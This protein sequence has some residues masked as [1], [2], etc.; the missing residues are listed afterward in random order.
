MA[1]VVFKKG[2]LAN[3]PQELA[4]GTLYV[5]TDERA[6][7]LDVNG[8]SRIRIGDFQEV[9]DLAALQEIESPSQTALY[10]VKDI[11]CLAKYDGTQWKQINPDTGATKGA[12]DGTGKDDFGFVYDGE[13]R[14]LTLTVSKKFIDNADLEEKIGDLG[15]DATVVDYITKKISEITGQE[16][17]LGER[18]TKL[19]GTVGDNSKGLVKDV[20]DLKTK[21]GDSS[22]S[23]QISTAVKAAKKELIGEESTEGTE[24]TI[25]AAKKHAE[26][27]DADL[28]AELIGQDGDGSEADTI[29]GA[30]KYADEQ[31]AAKVASTYKAGGSKNFA[32]LSDLLTK[33]NEGVVYNINDE[34]T[35]DDTFVDGGS[36]TY[37]AG[38]N[39][40]CID[41]GDESYKWDVLAGFVDL[42][43]Y[44]KT[45]DVDSKDTALKTELI[46]TGEGVTAT[47][48]KGAVTEA[49]TDAA[50]KDAALK[51]ELIGEGTSGDEDTIKG[52]KKYADEKLAAS[53]AWGEF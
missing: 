9:A 33:E 14:T 39:V 43:A 12:V 46:G 26:L 38:T 22:V 31:I 52:A 15:E 17:S 49:E 32:D 27:K 6:I 34:F 36:H 24:D 37:P 25:K 50:T 21:V 35:S 40:V 1:N 20:D 23:E 8:E 11:N 3:L 5:T 19:E 13:T 28:K 18:V 51:T 2:L 10:Y 44:A 48:I 41:T 4:E 16:T 45:S 42:S 30:K 53:L 7:Y 29:K 47:T